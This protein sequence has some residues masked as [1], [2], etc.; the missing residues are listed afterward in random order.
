MTDLS[1]IV[2][3]KTYRAFRGGDWPSFSDFL[4][5]SRP[6]VVA[7]E[8]EE[9]VAM[10]Q[11]NYSV[12]AEQDRDGQAEANQQRQ[13]QVFF[14]KHAPKM[15]ACRVPW[16]T[17][18]INTN[19]SVFI[20]ESPSWVPKF[21]GSLL[22]TDDVY[23]VLNSETAQRIRQ[24]ILAQRYYYCNHKISRF[25]APK[26][27][28]ITTKPT[29]EA[30]LQPLP[31]EPSE[32]TRVTQIPRNLIFDFDYT[33]NF[34]CPSCRTEL[35]NNNKHHVI[36]PI[37]NSIS[38]KIKHLVIDKIDQQPVDI[39]WAGG[40][41]FI[42]EV[43]VDLMEYCIASGKNIRHI[44]Q[45]NG[46]YLI[47]KSDLLEQLLPHVK[48]LRISFDAATADTYSRI[49]VGG[50]WENLLANVRHV[51]QQIRRLALKTTV[52]IDFVVQEDNYREIPLL[53]KL[54]Q[55][56]SI[57]TIYYQRMWNWGTWPL[58][59]FNRRNIYNP[60]HA[61]YQQLLTAFNLAGHHP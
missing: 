23:A 31:Y 18:G 32:Q 1:K 6:A 50:V 24:E 9:F 3:E 51:Q 29:G 47:A 45:T 16:N 57:D 55:D 30:D 26:A 21:V 28:S 14:D 15:F 56:M 12:I 35:I 22:E 58:E 49:R 8:I 7:H 38:D 2:D 41:P 39:R 48:E 53:R 44:I 37:N 43:Y 20:C 33:C 60:E 11:Q 4:N 61:D 59:E 34:R 52:S 10:M 5:G 19:G 40:E 27:N 25:L 46:S 13:Q 36:R 42:S 17:M 54:A